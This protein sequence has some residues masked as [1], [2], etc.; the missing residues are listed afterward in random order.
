MKFALFALGNSSYPQFCSYGKFVHESLVQLG[1]QQIME[2]E[3]SDEL[4]GQEESFYKWST[5]IY[6]VKIELS[7]Q[8]MIV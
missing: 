6:Q 3:L 5:N 4:N 2:L 8:I 7:K 1:A